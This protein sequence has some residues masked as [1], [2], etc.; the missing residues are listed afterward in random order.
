MDKKTGATFRALVLAMLTFSLLGFSSTATS[1][2]DGKAILILD[3]SGS[4][5]GRIE[6]TPKISIAQDVIND[7]LTK[8]PEEQQ[9]GLMLYGHR[10]KG[11][12]DDI[13]LLVAPGVNT[14]T[15]IAESINDINPKGKTPLSA[16][17][18]AA[19]E[20]LR[21]EENAATVILVSD[22]KETCNLDPCAVGTQLEESG[23][24]FTAHVIGFDVGESEDKAQ[25]QCLAENTGGKFLTADNAE[26]LAEALAQVSVITEFSISIV[27]KEGPKKASI[28]DGLV[29]SLNNLDSSE[30][31]IDNSDAVSVEQVLPAGSYRVNVVRSADDATATLEFKVGNGFPTGHVLELPLLLPD[32]TLAAPAT[33]K[34]G[35]KLSVEWTGP[36]TRGDYISLADPEAEAFR[37]ITYDSTF[38]GSPVTLTMPAKPGTYELRYIDHRLN[39][40]L[41]SIPLVVE[42]VDATIKA[43]ANAE[44]G[45]TIPVEWTGPGYRSD[46][47][48]VARVDEPGHKHVNYTYTQEGTPLQLEMPAEPGTYE[49]RYILHQDRTVLASQ[50]IDVSE[51][52][53]SIEVA[54]TAS[55]GQEISVNWEGPGYQSD[56]ISVAKKDS[57]GNSYI[58]YTYTQEGTPLKLKMPGEPGEYEVRYILSQDRKILASTSIIVEDAAVTLDAPASA[59]IGDTIDV[60]WTG[61]DNQNDF[62]SITKSGQEATS[63]SHYTYT[64][65]TTPLQLK[66]PAEPGEYQIHYILAEGYRSLESVDITLTNVSAKVTAPES[67][68]VGQ[69]IPVNWEGPGYQQD[70]ISVAK[71]GSDDNRYVNYTYTRE[72]TPLTLQMPG[73]PGEYEVRYVLSQGSKILATTRIV[74]EEAEATLDVPAVLGAGGNARIGWTGPD[75]KNDY[76]SIAKPNQDGRHYEHYVY[77]RGNKPVTLKLPAQPGDYQIRYILAEGQRI[78]ESVDVTVKDVSASVTAQETAKIGEPIEV[79]FVGPYNDG[80]FISVAKK[81]S[82]SN[83]YLQFARVKQGETSVRLRMPY[84]PGGYEIR[85]IMSRK[86]RMLARTNITVEPATANL[87]TPEVADVGESIS[88]EWDG[89]DYNG[90]FI[91]VSKVGSARNKYVNAQRTARG[92]PLDLN[93]PPT[94]GEYEIQYLL[95]DRQTVLASNPIVIVMPNV[96]LSAPATASVGEEILI[97]WDGPGN[98]RDYVSVAKPNSANNKILRNSLLRGKSPA[99][100]KMPDE[101]G[102]YEIRY[103][104]QQGATV[105]ATET[106]VVQ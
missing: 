80:D 100:L 19:A 32:A 14:R 55:V 7:L 29:W 68:F 83:H 26:E 17:V 4:M 104:L 52:Q 71:T 75:N 81:G 82:K 87:N 39:Q 94:A 41:V 8:I 91:V 50:P 23:I 10:R 89:P 13:E 9:L 86:G 98:A 38:N 3:S 96:S 30:T 77:T 49:I 92:N 56:F 36:G 90:D 78:L 63:Y 73:E 85:Y 42:P 84:E 24:D 76:I 2:D 93:M 25:L 35:S 64:R 53:V 6:E 54:E 58:N 51:I 79:E 21:I 101:P 62:I 20:E 99:K 43:A 28:K 57:V 31:L 61:P 27:A 22:G 34:A 102:T 11:D 33:A 18:L 15:A 5:W 66:L 106:I 103:Q 37:Y 97:E 65:G 45:E 44:A 70:Y 12:C 69:D 16:A 48:T 88:V 72:G 47:I 95:A 1:S 46:Y 60:G 59:V 105:L 74:V 67:A 40:A